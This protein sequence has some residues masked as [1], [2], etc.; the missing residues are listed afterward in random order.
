MKGAL[1]AKFKFI[2]SFLVRRGV[3]RLTRKFYLL[4]RIYRFVIERLIPKSAINVLEH[5]MFLDSVDVLQLFTNGIYENLSTNLLKKEIKKGDIVLDIGAHI[6]YYTLIFAKLVGNNGRVYAFEPNPTNFAILKKNIELNEYKNVVLIQKAV[7]DKCSKIKLFLADINTGDH[8]I[9]DSHD[10]RK[11]IEV[12]SIKLDDY[13]KDFRKNINFIKMDIQGAESCAIYGM[14]KLL[15]KNKNLKLTSE[16][17]PIGLKNSGIEPSDYLKMLLN[18]GFKLYN[19][20]EIVGKIEQ[21]NPKK[22]LKIYTP[23]KENFT[24]LLC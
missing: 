16:F 1:L 21:T 24:N 3:E 17:W 22:L 5:K 11:F 12:E 9:Y 4:R 15:K 7:S 14:Q 6:G 13:F 2:E 8:R 18:H 23:Q 10:G 20:D 19:I